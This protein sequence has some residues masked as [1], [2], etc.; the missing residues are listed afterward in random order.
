MKDQN[1]K[2]RSS[3]KDS[4]IEINRDMRLDEAMEDLLPPMKQGQFGALED[5]ILRNG[6]MTPL[7][8]WEEENMLLNGYARFKICEE[9]QIMF[10]SVP[11]SLPSREMAEYWRINAHLPGRH[12][13]AWDR[14]ILCLKMRPMLEARMREGLA[15]A[16][17]VDREGV[18]LEE[19]ILRMLAHV[20]GI[21]TEL[22]RK[23]ALIQDTIQLSTIDELA[24]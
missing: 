8:W 4:R 10:M 3:W 16:R 5:D 15:S 12:L 6:C 14:A 2:N 20:A 24:A 22:L 1:A 9:R 7:V 19:V 21:K 23:V 17:F 18:S 13:S 11:V